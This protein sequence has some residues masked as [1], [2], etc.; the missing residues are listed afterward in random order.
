M[1]HTIN[2]FWLM[3]WTDH[4]PMIVMI[5]KLREKNKVKCERYVPETSEVYNDIEVKVTRST[6]RDGF[7]VRE[8]FLRRGNQSQTVVHYWYTAWPDHKAPPSP[9]QLV[10]MAV[11]VEARRCDNDNR[12]R[13]PV[14]VHCSAGI[15]RTGCFMGVSIGMQQILEE[16]AVDVLGIVCSM[17][18]DRGGMVQTAEQYEFIHRALCLFE[19]SLPEQAGE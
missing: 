2:D 16:N 3:V 4:V 7:T 10:A 6:A 5:T 13:G 1:P 18:R 19:R 15:G 17:R 14:I 8:L 12:P 9:K 11:E